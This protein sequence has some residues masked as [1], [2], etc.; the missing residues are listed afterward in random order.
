MGKG[1]KQHPGKKGDAPK[2]ASSVVQNKK[3][4][5]LGL[6][7]EE[8]VKGLIKVRV[9]TG[10]APCKAM[11]CVS[12]WSARHLLSYSKRLLS[13]ASAGRACT[14]MHAINALTKHD[15]HQAPL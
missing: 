1:S 12:C 4:L 8:Q 7:I 3:A 9:G 11:Q 14:F 6:D 15:H 5:E 10:H 13:A 2:G